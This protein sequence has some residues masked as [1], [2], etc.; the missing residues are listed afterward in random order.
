MIF[1]MTTATFTAVHVA[2]S[3]I[4]IVSGFVV[5]Y[6]L[7]NSKRLDRW[8]ALFLVTTVATSV[9][10]FGFPFDHLLPSHKLGI[11]SLAVLAVAILA[12]RDA[13]HG[14]LALDLRGR[15]RHGSLFEFLRLD[16]AV[17]HESP[18]TDGYGSDADRAAIP[19]GAARSFGASCCAGHCRN[20]KF[21]NVIA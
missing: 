13:P 3:L 10:G 7:L 15:R 19:G 16:R 2:F 17:L 14:C 18:G 6:G 21:R 8:T 12:L 1:G 11:I 5:T 20:K 9:T 4:G